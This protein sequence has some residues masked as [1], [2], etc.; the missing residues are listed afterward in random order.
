MLSKQRTSR[1]GR[2]LARAEQTARVRTARDE[3]RHMRERANTIDGL[4]APVLHP[5]VPTG[6]LI[7][8]VGVEVNVVVLLQAALGLLQPIGARPGDRPRLPDAALVKA[9]TRVA[10][11]P[12]P[13]LRRRRRLGKLIAARV[14]KALVFLGVDRLGVLEGISRAICS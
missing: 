12:L 7:R 9:P 10:E 14:A 8:G 11:P 5:P 6:V 4:E 13:A 2:S 1:I 3:L